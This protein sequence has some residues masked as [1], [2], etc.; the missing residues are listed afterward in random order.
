MK[1]DHEDLLMLALTID[2]CSKYHVP[3]A[4]LLTHVTTRRQLHIAIATLQFVIDRKKEA[5]R[6]NENKE[7]MS[8]EETE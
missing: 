3:F 6:P 7:G 8:E 5:E 2:D 4:L 1:V